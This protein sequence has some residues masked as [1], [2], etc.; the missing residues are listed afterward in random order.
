MVP[1]SILATL[2][3]GKVHGFKQ[4]FE[5]ELGLACLE[6]TCSVGEL[7]RFYEMRLPQLVYHKIVSRMAAASVTKC[8]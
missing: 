5:K 2:G 3:I 6:A 7:V 4:I 8:S 1:V